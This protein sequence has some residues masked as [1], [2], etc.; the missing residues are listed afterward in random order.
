[1]CGIFLALIQA[2]ERHYNPLAARKAFDTFE[3]L[4]ND[5]KLRKLPE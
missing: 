2:F 1:M 5:G 4:K 3:K